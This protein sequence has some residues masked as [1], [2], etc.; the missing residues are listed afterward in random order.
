MSAVR[1]WAT[2]SPVGREDTCGQGGRA[3]PLSQG[4]LAWS[5]DRLHASRPATPRCPNSRGGLYRELC[6]CGFYNGSPHCTP[7]EKREGNSPLWG[8]RVGRWGTVGSDTWPRTG[9]ENASWEQCPCGGSMRAVQGPWGSG[10]RPPP[11]PPCLCPSSA[12]RLCP[13]TSAPGSLVQLWLQ[14]VGERRQLPPG[15]DAQP[16]APLLAFLHVKPCGR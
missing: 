2:S 3:K 11:R 10:K 16:R 6:C 9:V 14:V 4:R 12:Q 13:R 7:M 1:K 15:S 5:P 8:P